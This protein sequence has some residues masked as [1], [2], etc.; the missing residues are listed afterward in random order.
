MIDRRYLVRGLLGRGGMAEVFR[1]TDTETDREVALKML[2]GVESRDAC[3]FR[4]E[5]DVL[6]RLDHPGL[7]KLR[8]SGTHDG[9]P[10]LV[11]DLAGGLSLAD[12]LSAGP[13]GPD[14]A[15]MVGQQVADALAH[16]HE[17]GI[18]HRD[19]KPSNILFDDRGRARLADFGIARLAGTPS[20]T[21]TGQLVG[22]A[23][24]LAPEQVEGGEAGPAADVYALGL[25]VIE[26]VTGRPCYSGGQVEAAV[27]RLH[28]SP[29]VPPDLPRWWRDVLSAMT[30]REPMRRPAVNA[31]ADSFRRRTA[32][33]VLA[34]TA[35]LDIVPSAA[36][37]GP[38]A[39]SALPD[40]ERDAEVTR[41]LAAPDDGTAV[42]AVVPS[43]GSARSAPTRRIMALVG[44][45][46]TAALVL[47]LGAWNVAG[48]DAP[49][50]AP[51][52]DPDPAPTT[53][54]A[55]TTV[56][57][58]TVAP[59]SPAAESGEGPPAP[60]PQQSDGSKT[61]GGKGKS[62]AKG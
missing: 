60:A 15:L 24:Y 54:V 50:T 55:P 57:P 53:T 20:L 31:V 34:T 3:R 4:S 16:A 59:A 13:I 11:L 35:A 17:M 7:V 40:P 36:P 33:P 5:A 48:Q 41:T 22:S 6:A 14:R 38:D 29:D 49:A 51:P 28:R 21:R 45:A 26:C 12:A 39:P 30:A 23:P 47:A 46:L 1:A 37:A 56:T 43:T 62:K 32:E 9:V 18:V 25:V 19:V 8:G 61:K 58:T 10:Y 2:Q 42:L 52:S 27:S 44:A